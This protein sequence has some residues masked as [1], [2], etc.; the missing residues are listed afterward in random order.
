M[1]S[2]VSVIKVQI[3]VERNWQE[4]QCINDGKVRGD[5][6]EA[7]QSMGTL[8]GILNNYSMSARWI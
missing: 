2:K 1:A 6:V 8:G 5:T 7:H 3:T 4:S